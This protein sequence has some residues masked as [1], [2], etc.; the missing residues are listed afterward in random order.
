M[1]C[2]FG[3]GV[4]TALFTVCV[5]GVTSSCDQLNQAIGFNRD[6][7]GEAYPAALKESAV[8][9]ATPEPVATTAP[10]AKV[11]ATGNCTDDD[12]ADDKQDAPAG[13]SLKGDESGDCDDADE[14]DDKDDDGPQA[15]ATP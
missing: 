9:E 6:G 12:D 8:A 5:L 1:G 14:A 15:A 7:G 2:K 13:A 11:A 4:F 3:K 10:E